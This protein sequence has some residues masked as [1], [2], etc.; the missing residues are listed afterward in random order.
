MLGDRGGK[1]SDQGGTLYK[2]E[3]I[4]QQGQ[5]IFKADPVG[6]WCQLPPDTASRTFHSEYEWQDDA[7]WKERESLDLRQRPMATYEIH[8]T[9]FAR[10]AWEDEGSDPEALANYRD[11]APRVAKHVKDLGFDSVELLPVAEHPFDGSWGYQVTGYF[12]PT[13]RFGTPDDFRYFVDHLHQEG[14]AVLI[15]WVPAHFVKD[16]HGLG[17]FDGTALYEHEDPRRGEHPDWGTYV[18]NYGRFEVRNFLVSNALYWLEEFHV[19]GLRVDAVASMLYLDY[20]RKEDE[21]IPN[22]HGGNE[23]YEALECLREVNRRIAER[24]PGRF[25]VAEESTAWPGITQPVDE[26]GLGFTFKWNMGWMHDTLGYFQADP[27]FRSHHHDKLTFAMVYEY[28]EAYVNPLSHDEVVHGKGSL[29][30]KMPGDSW[31]KA[32]NLRALYAYQFARPGKVL[33]FMGSE[34]GSPRE[35]NHEGGLDLYLLDDPDRKGLR[36]F[37]AELGRLY[38]ATPALWRLD[39]DAAGFQWLV[40]SDRSHSVFAFARYAEPAEVVLDDDQDS[41]SLVKSWKVPEAHALVVLNLTPVPRDDYR[42]GVPAAGTYRVQLSSDDKAWGGSGYPRQQVVTTESVPSA[43][44][45]ESLELT[46]PP[47]SAMVLLPAKQP[48]KASPPKIASAKTAA[49]NT[50]AGKTTAK[51]D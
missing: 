46:L 10:S 33:L 9:S 37:V 18:F 36:D 51:S 2:Y 3:I 47:L 38:H 22:H 48:P 4:S 8:L 49:A 43:G 41:E 19:D 35:W 12:A 13:S 17:R 32:A 16:A 5:K 44:W 14:I 15:D 23:N 20:S 28:S 7:W 27:Y 6:A 26:G 42:L 24:C 21:W 34:L 29:W 40:A 39:H 25:T 50:A 1:E 11:L 30:S 45:K 31:R